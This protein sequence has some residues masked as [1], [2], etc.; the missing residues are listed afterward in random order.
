MN[1]EEFLKYMKNLKN[2]HDFLDELNN[3]FNKYNMPDNQ[4]FENILFDNCIE[5]LEKNLGLEM[6]SVGYSTLSWY[7]Y[8]NEFGKAGQKM[9]WNKEEVSIETLDDLWEQILREQRGQ[10]DGKMVGKV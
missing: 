8:E 1:K 9:W 4:I 10:E 7:I 6:D 5:L 3:M 2:E